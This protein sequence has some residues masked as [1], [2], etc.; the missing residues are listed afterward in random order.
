MRR[1]KY[2]SKESEDKKAL[3]KLSKE[4]LI[5]LYVSAKIKADEYDKLKDLIKKIIED[6]EENE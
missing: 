2:M 4:S 5:S 6:H 1:V 3:M